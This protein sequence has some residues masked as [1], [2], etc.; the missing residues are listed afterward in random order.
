MGNVC[1]RQAKRCPLSLVFWD[2]RGDDTDVLFL[3]RPPAPFKKDTSPQVAG[4]SVQ[5]LFL[6]HWLP[7]SRLRELVTRPLRRD[8]HLHWTVESQTRS[9]FTFYHP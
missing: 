2:K 4:S 1:R 9:L 7:F 6:G 5:L 3:R 8:Q